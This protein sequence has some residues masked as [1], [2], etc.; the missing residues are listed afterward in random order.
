MA[1]R[2]AAKQRASTIIDTFSPEKLR[3]DI[4][5]GPGKKKTGARHYTV[6]DLV[7]LKKAKGGGAIMQP[8]DEL[9]KTVLKLYT[10]S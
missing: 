2:E 4:K 8:I 9:Q 7:N 6:N 10:T 5:L 1:T 3:A